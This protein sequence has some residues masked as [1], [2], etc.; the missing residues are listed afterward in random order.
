VMLIPVK[1]AVELH[2][3]ARGGHAFGT[4]GMIQ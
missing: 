3:Y 1:V 4:I 2:A